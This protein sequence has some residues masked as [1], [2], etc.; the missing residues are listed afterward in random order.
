ANY[1]VRPYSIDQAL[2][3]TV[4]HKHDLHVAVYQQLRGEFLRQELQ[5]GRLGIGAMISMEERFE[6]LRHR[7]PSF[8]ARVGARMRKRL[9]GFIVTAW[10]KKQRLQRML[11]P[12][13]PSLPRQLESEP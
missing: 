7:E 10:G 8:F 5:D 12:S 1:H 9:A 6:A 3:G 2:A 13:A 4:T 11:K